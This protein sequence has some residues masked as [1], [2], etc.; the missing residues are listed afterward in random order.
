MSRS[1]ALAG[2]DDD[3][4]AMLERVLRDDCSASPITVERGVN[5]SVL[6]S[7]K[8]DLLL[9]DIDR[10]EVDPLELVRRLR[11]VLPDCI[12]AVYSGILKR[13]WSLACHLA[14][15]SALLSKSSTESELGDGL[16]EAFDTGCFTDPRFDVEETAR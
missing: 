16:C 9:C 10:S 14:G 1:S 6:G 3:R 4:L 2:I 15:A 8:L 12:I 5:V 13:S 11:F 7:L